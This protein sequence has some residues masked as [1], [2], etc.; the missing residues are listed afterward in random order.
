MKAHYGGNHVRVLASH[1]DH[2]RHRSRR[3]GPQPG[4]QPRP[5]RAHRR[6][7]QPHPGPHRLPR[8]AARR[9]GHLRAGHVD[10]GVRRVT[11]PAPRGDRDGA[12]RRADRRGDRGTRPAA[13]RGRHH[14]RLRQRA[15]RRH[16]PPRARA[17]REGHPLRRVRRLGWRG[18]RPARPVDHARRFGAVLREARAD[19]RVDRGPGRR[20]TLLRPRRPGRRGALR[21]DGAQRH[22]VRRHA[23]DRRGLRPAARR[24]RR[25]TGRA[26]PRSSSRGTRA[27]SSRS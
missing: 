23:A 6:P 26:S 9:R 8:R 15:L 21:Q 25:D 1:R 3:H 11:D 19:L 4:P 22:R 2:R 18:G 7:A 24:A 5:A 13:R 14:H 27:I 17:A 12:G 20:H 10:A 16:P